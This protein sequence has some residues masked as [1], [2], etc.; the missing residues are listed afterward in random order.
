MTHRQRELLEY[1]RR[2]QAVN[3][4]VSPSFREMMEAMGV[5]SLG[6]ISRHLDALEAQGLLRRDRSGV[7]AIH[8]TPKSADLTGYPDTAII[9][10]FSRR[11]W[12][13]DRQLAALS[14]VGVNS[15]VHNGNDT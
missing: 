2:Y 8:L 3:R 12:S 6:C 15:P 9:A 1:I 11:F 14:T 7:R 10:E 4:G 5:A 13:R